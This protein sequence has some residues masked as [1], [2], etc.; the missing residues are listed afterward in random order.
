[1]SVWCVG[2]NYSEHAKE[3][4]NTVPDKPLFFLKSSSALFQKPTLPFPE[5]VLSLHHE[6]EL[7]FR[8]DHYLRISHVALALDLTDRQ[9]QNELKSKG[10]P[11]TL[12]K[13]FKNSCPIS[14]WFAFDP[15]EIY[16]FELF[17][18][19]LTKQAGEMN[20]MIFKWPELVSFLKLHFPLAE[21]DILLSGT[22][23]GVGSLSRGDLLKSV[24][25]NANQKI[26]IEWTLKIE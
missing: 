8:F 14:P 10:E 24:L 3:L 23:A 5:H 11:W 16:S 17:V 25:K 20:Q 19:G 21:N 2:R 9:R 12:A 6:L 4:G 7:A 18:N 26:L 13:S 15:N 22:P 1:M